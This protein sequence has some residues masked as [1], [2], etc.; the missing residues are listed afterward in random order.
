[1]FHFLV[2]LRSRVFRVWRVG[3]NVVDWMAHHKPPM[4][5]KASCIPIS[6]VLYQPTYCKG[7]IE[8]LLNYLWQKK[9]LCKSVPFSLQSTN[10]NSATRYSTWVMGDVIKRHNL[11]RN[12]S[13]TSGRCI[14]SR[15]GGKTR[16]RRYFRAVLF[17]LENSIKTVRTGSNSSCKTRTG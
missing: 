11:L 8:I 16:E 15:N 12:V 14:T 3:R 6:G 7:K 13:P 9:G 4:C 17:F 1:M 2:L 10:R 5:Q